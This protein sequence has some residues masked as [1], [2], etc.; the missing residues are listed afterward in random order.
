[1]VS[2]EY[3]D[4]EKNEL[5]PHLCNSLQIFDIYVDIA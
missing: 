3:F 5:G 2:M 1:M 4:F